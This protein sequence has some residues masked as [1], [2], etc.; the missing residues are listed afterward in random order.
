MICVWL[1]ASR[2]KRDASV[3]YFGKFSKESTWEA[4]QLMNKQTEV[5]H[6]LS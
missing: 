5:F 6:Q 3:S 1:T 4:T 2:Q